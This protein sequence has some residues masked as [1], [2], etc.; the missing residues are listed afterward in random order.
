MSDDD[1]SDLSDLSI[2]LK[3]PD[4]RE[5][6]SNWLEFL[7]LLTT[8]LATIAI[9]LVIFIV[10]EDVKS[11]VKSKEL[12]TKYIELSVD[13]LK[14]TPS[15][16]TA[17][18]RRWAIENINKY[19]E[20]PLS[21]EAKQELQQEALPTALN[22]SSSPV[23]H[24]TVPGVPRNIEFVILT[25][26]ENSSMKRE[27]QIFQNNK[28]RASYHYI[29]G[30]DG[31]IEKLVDEDNIAWHAGSSQWQGKSNLNNITVGIGLT[32]LATPDGKN[33]MNLPPAHPA[34][35]PDYPDAQIESLVTLLADI[36]KRNNLQVEAI[37][38]KQDIAPKRRRTDLFGQ[39]LQKV[40]S[41]VNA[42]MTQ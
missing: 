27:L 31:V 41:R 40:R 39:P 9:P 10:G 12:E 6:P 15:P 38:T 7:K 22:I 30:V 19:S 36:L 37:L 34:V 3:Q 25:D 32:H 5:A 29:V 23:E 17:S 24:F 18:L 1:L 13:I 16:E 2:V 26:T 11:S 35:G 8:M 20:I 21:V 4:L 42:L 28:V 14:E 33:W